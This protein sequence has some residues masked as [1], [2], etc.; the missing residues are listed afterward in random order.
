MQTL[1]ANAAAPSG[2][3]AASDHRRWTVLWAAGI[4]L[5][6]VWDLLFLNKRAFAHL[7]QGFANTMIIALAVTACTL[8]LAWTTANALHRLRSRNHRTLSMMLTFALNL[9]RSVP[10]VVGVLLGYILITSL[11][12]Q[13]TLRSAWSV[14]LCVSLTIG[15]FIFVEMTDLLLERI[16]YFRKKDFYN[17]M[18]ASGVAEFRIVNFDILWKNSRLH[19]FNKLIAVFGMAVFLQCSVDFIVSVGLSTRVN[20]IAMPPTLG[21][22]LANIDSKQDILAIGHTLTHPLYI[23]NLFFEHLQGLSTAFFI[24]F[25][26]LCMHKIGA[27]FAERHRL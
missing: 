9:I 12:Q 20:N 14:L 26:L 16:A 19:I 5:V 11:M 18:M 8:V 23:H 2:A 7:A 4:L 13:E 27:G 3:H 22:L 21:S 10:Q 6:G 17:A 15:F 24:V 25:T 1:R